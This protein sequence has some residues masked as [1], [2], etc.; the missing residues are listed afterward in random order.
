MSKR[1]KNAFTLTE[2]ILT[3][4]IIGILSAVVLPRFGGT[5]LIS[6]LKLRS[7]TSQITSDIRYTRQ[8]AITNAGHYIIK[9]DFIQKEYKIYK[10]SISDVNQIGE[11]KKIS[12]DIT[13][14]GTDQFDF[15]SLGNVL[16]LGAGLSLSLNTSQYT[17]T[18]EPPTGAVIVEKIS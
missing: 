1:N 4:I 9:F 11:I 12:S 18:A 14:S 5:G 16:F 17:I 3:L 8:L 7:T 10:D 6:K 13:C 2:L 15:F